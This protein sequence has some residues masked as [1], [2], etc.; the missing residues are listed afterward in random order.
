MVSAAQVAGEPAGAYAVASEKAMVGE[1]DQALALFQ[2]LLS[3]FLNDPEQR[4]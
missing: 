2:Q 3:D 1:W 4:A